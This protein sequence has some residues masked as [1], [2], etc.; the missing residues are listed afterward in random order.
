MTMQCNNSTKRWH[1][2]RKEA[3]VRLVTR[4]SKFGFDVSGP[5]LDLLLC[6]L[7]AKPWLW[8]IRDAEGVESDV[9][10]M[11]ILDQKW[12]DRT[13]GVRGAGGASGFDKVGA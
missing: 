3:V 4:T 9:L 11:R 2:C 10:K 13:T 7:H 12:A 5:A 8:Q 6:S 1:Q